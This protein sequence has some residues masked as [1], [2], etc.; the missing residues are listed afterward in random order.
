MVHLLQGNAPR[1]SKKPRNAEVHSTMQ[2]NKPK[3]KTFQNRAP[4]K[5]RILALHQICTNCAVQISII[6]LKYFITCNATRCNATQRDT[7]ECKYCS[8]TQH[9][10]AVRHNTVQNLSWDL[11]CMRLAGFYTTYQ[12]QNYNRNLAVHAVNEYTCQVVATTT[13]L[14]YLVAL[15]W[16]RI[17]SRKLHSGKVE[18]GSNVRDTTFVTYKFCTM[19]NLVNKIHSKRKSR[20]E[21]PNLCTSGT[22]VFVVSS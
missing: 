18:F 15:L 8:E 5:T 12:L 1:Y 22:P 4:H 16:L 13:S 11:V 10:T 21:H 20:F 3:H 2:S 6:S 7:L 19:Q 14:C 9:N 17:C